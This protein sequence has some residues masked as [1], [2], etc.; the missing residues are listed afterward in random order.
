[1]DDLSGETVARQAGD[2]VGTSE[3]RPDKQSGEE[4]S[5]CLKGTYWS[6]LPVEMQIEIVK[7]KNLDDDDRLN[8]LCAYPELLSIISESYPHDNPN[9]ANGWKGTEAEAP[10]IY[11]KYSSEKKMFCVEMSSSACSRQP[12]RIFGLKHNRVVLTDLDSKSK[13]TAILLDAL[14]STSTTTRKLDCSGANKADFLLSF[15]FAKVLKPSCLDLGFD[16]NEEC[17]TLNELVEAFPALFKLKKFTVLGPVRADGDS[18]FSHLS[19]LPRSLCFNDAFLHDGHV[20]KFLRA[21]VSTKFEERSPAA[22]A[23]KRLINWT[24]VMNYETKTEEGETMRGYRFLSELV[25]DIIPPGSKYKR[26]LFKLHLTVGDEQHV[27][28]VKEEVD[29]LH[30]D[31]LIQLVNQ[32]ARLDEILGTSDSSN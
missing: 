29:H 17:T 5:A 11:I 6:R 8:L 27:I 12:H 14:K 4:L 18:L 21:L 25:A 30:E 26:R 19:K 7:Q 31:R 23:L 13:H 28:Y 20:V 24:F 22:A 16:Y 10:E 2:L 3:N 32:T 9:T 15:A 1:M